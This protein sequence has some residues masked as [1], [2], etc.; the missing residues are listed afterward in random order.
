MISTL[1]RRVAVLALLLGASY[2]SMP[3]MVCG[4]DRCPMD[5]VARQACKKMGGDCCPGA[6]RAERAPL[7]PAPSFAALPSA[8][9]VPVPVR[10]EPASVASWRPVN[11]SALHPEIGRFTL[12]AAFLI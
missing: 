7:P 6:T 4:T 1:L 9:A 3:G 10:S 8:P 5:A 2:S 12:F 11:A